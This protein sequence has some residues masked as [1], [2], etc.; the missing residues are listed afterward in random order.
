[1]DESAAEHLPGKEPPTITVVVATT[2]EARRRVEIWRAV[3]SVLGQEGVD[4]DL[5]FVVNGKR[6]DQELADRLASRDRITV[7]FLDEPSYPAAVSYGR[8]LVKKEFFA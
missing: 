5:V 8:T 7:H 2:C 3:E 1:M 6:F 4:V